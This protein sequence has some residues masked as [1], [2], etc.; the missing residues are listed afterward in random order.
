MILKK[1][2]PNNRTVTLEDHVKNTIDYYYDHRTSRAFK[3][4][5]DTITCSEDEKATIYEL[6][7]KR[8]KNRDP[9]NNPYK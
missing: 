5:I 3:P 8:I 1:I 9:K 7:Y 4:Y 6:A 2:D